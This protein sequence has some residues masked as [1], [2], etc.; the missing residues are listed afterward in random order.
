M[1]DDF[2]AIEKEA[3]DD[4]FDNHAPIEDTYMEGEISIQKDVDRFYDE[5]A[6]CTISG[7]DILAYISEYAWD[8][9]DNYLRSKSVRTVDELASPA[10]LATYESYYAFCMDVLAEAE[11]YWFDTEY[12]DFCDA[13]FNEHADLDEYL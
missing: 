1:I 6:S 2:E 7:E 12:D 3:I 4:Y 10:N 5:P 9:L 11:K 13:Y 8:I